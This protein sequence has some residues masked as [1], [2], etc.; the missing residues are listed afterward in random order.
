MLRRKCGIYSIT[1]KIN[2]KRY[3]GST[4]DLK[5]R[6]SDHKKLLNQK[7]H[8]NSYLQ[9][10]WNKYGQNNFIFEVLEVTSEKFLRKREQYYID[11]FK[12]L[13]GDFGYNLTEVWE[14]GWTPE[15]R[16]KQSIKMTGKGN[17]NFGKKMTQEEKNR[18]HAG[19][20]GVKHHKARAV[21]QYDKKGNFIKE[22]DFM[23]QA[24]K[25]LNIPWVD[26]QQTC[27]GL[28]KSC[29]GFVWKYANPVAPLNG[30]MNFKGP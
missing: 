11:T 19:M 1:N 15:H 17:P 24:A 13:E 21:L 12:C 6:F 26:I 8:Y 28:Q 3:I 16:R 20:R 27:K 4:I 9:S 5:L 30:A 22:W 14:L 29:R 18:W 25:A 23:A 10:A 2:K 7:N